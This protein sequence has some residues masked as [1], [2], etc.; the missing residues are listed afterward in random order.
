MGIA[1]NEMMDRQKACIPELQ[2][3][4]IS[5]VVSPTFELLSNV[6]P[7]TSE[8]LIVIDNNR[9]QWE[10]LNLSEGNLMSLN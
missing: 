1:P 8:L 10:A 5:T 9:K 4:F 6:F 2:I 3:E 7:E